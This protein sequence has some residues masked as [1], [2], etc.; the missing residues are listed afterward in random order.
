MS[1]RTSPRAS[2]RRHQYAILASSPGSFYRRFFAYIGSYKYKT[3][4][5][6]TGKCRLKVKSGGRTSQDGVK[7]AYWWRILDIR[8]EEKGTSFHESRTSGWSLFCGYILS[9]LSFLFFSLTISHRSDY[10]WI[11][12]PVTIITETEMTNCFSK[13]SYLRGNIQ[14]IWNRNLLTDVVVLSWSAKFINAC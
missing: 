2:H 7:M 5:F 11:N 3:A 12:I 9:V 14:E 4:A 6:V 10:R 1:S 8:I 13:I